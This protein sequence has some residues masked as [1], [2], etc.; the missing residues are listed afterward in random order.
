MKLTG[1][2]IDAFLRKP[3]PTILA[4]LLYGPDQGLVRERADRVVAT[5]AGDNTDPFRIAE[6]T[7]EQLRDDPV[8]LADEAAALPFSGGRRIVRV[9]EGRDSMVEAVRNLFKVGRGGGLVVVEAAELGP[10]S[11]LRQLFE[12]APRAA[13]LPCYI[14]EGDGLRQLIQQDLASHGLTVTP[15][16]TD[17]LATLLGADRGLTRSELQKLALYKGLSGQVEVEDVVAVIGGAG[18][19]SLD[20]IAYAACTGDFATL[21]RTLAAA[22]AE[23][24]PAIPLLRAVARHLHRL[25]QANAA[26]ANGSTA[27]QAIDGLKPLVLFRLQAQFRRQMSLWRPERLAE[28]FLLLTETELQC[29]QTGAPQDLLCHRALFHLAKLARSV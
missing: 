27:K 6:L 3:D 22:A 1:Q 29:K 17:V 16:A 19:V 8:R 4:I 2:R 18:A 14:D 20:A 9:R 28:A 5:V 26:V 7:A 23:G 15:E 12:A 25:L 24:T 10:R 13:A 21:D 11:P